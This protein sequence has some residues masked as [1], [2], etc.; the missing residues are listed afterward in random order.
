MRLFVVFFSLLF[1][2]VKCES[3][4]VP[5]FLWS[6]KGLISG[7]HEL[8]EV[9]RYNGEEKIFRK[10][11][12]SNPGI[13][14]TFLFDKLNTGALLRAFGAFSSSSDSEL[15]LV[16]KSVTSASTSVFAPYV[17]ANKDLFIHHFGR[18]TQDLT[19]SDNCDDVISQIA[20]P[21]NIVIRI[22]SSEVRDSDQCISRVVSVVD[23]LTRGNFIAILSSAES[24]SIQTSF[25]SQDSTIVQPQN[26]A[27]RTTSFHPLADAAGNAGVLYITP[28]ILFGIFIGFFIVFMLVF[29][30]CCLSGIEAPRR[31]TSTSLVIGKEY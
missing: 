12:P 29:A 11:M 20:Q 31:Y 24:D 27:A 10:Y 23:S 6:N 2:Y 18:E 14:V 16:Q 7:H 5:A 1:L 4:F 26:F 28:N 17:S 13:A 19:F 3:G 9:I 21:A 25:V 22:S 30:V 15:H 8:A